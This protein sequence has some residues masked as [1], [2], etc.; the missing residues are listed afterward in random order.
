MARSE[1]KKWKA[2]ELS[3]K[4]AMGNFMADERIK[5]KLLQEIEYNDEAVVDNL[6]MN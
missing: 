3:L 1:R 2:T 6:L 5:D 4:Q